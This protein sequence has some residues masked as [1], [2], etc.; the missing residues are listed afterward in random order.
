MDSLQVQGM[1]IAII[2]NGK[3]VFNKGLGVANT[4]S[5]KR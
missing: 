2:N 4:L 1:S 5:K 3:I